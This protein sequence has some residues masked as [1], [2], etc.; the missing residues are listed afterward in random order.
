MVTLLKPNNTGNYS[1][2]ASRE[3]KAVEG[4]SSSSVETT[5][6]VLDESQLDYGSSPGIDLGR[7]KDKSRLATKIV[8]PL[9][10]FYKL[11]SGPPMTQRERRRQ[12][13]AEAS[14]RNG[15]SHTW[16]HRAPW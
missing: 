4:V 11:M 2:T 5:G 1:E 13:M 9:S 16:F 7:T 8:S 3:T 14:I 10:A 15:A 12:A 6:P